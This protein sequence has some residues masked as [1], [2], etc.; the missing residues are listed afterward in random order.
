MLTKYSQ[1]NNVRKRLWNLHTTEFLI[2]VSVA[3]QLTKHFLSQIKCNQMRIIQTRWREVSHVWRPA[4]GHS[5]LLG[6]RVLIASILLDDKRNQSSKNSEGQIYIIHLVRSLSL[7]SSGGLFTGK[8]T[9]ELEYYN[10]WFKNNY[11]ITSLSNTEKNQVFQ[12][13]SEPCVMSKHFI[14]SANQT[15]P[16]HWSVLLRI[17]W[18]SVCLF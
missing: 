10:A 1:A 6:H 14:A 5:S 11:F 9:L 17:V 3:G 15:K 7:D 13:L 4:D 16:K 12:K 8:N 18:S 2:V